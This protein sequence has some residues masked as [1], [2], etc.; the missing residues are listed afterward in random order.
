MIVSKTVDERKKALAKI[1]PLQ[2]GDF[3]E[4]YRVL[5]ETFAQI[6]LTHPQKPDYYVNAFRDFFSRIM[7]RSKDVVVMRTLL[8]KIRG[9]GEKIP[10]EK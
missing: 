1:L 5:E 8:S 4:M 2:Q 3:E 10:N 6:S 9:Y 7:P